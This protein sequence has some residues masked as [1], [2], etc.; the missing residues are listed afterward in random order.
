MAAKNAE[1]EQECSRSTLIV[2]GSL[3]ANPK[4]DAILLAAAKIESEDGQYARAR[5]L[6]A[7][8]R[9]EAAPRSCLDEVRTA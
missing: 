7:R 4:S 3:E 1:R 8:A 2:R 6:L 9:N 5:V